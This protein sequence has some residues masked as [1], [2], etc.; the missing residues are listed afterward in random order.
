MVNLVDDIPTTTDD[1]EHVNC[2][3]E[4]PKGTK[5]ANIEKRNFKKTDFIINSNI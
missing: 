1:F 4:I 2:I 5:N 3:I